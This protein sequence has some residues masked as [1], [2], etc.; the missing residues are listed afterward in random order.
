MTRAPSAALEPCPNI[1]LR[2]L[3]CGNAVLRSRLEHE[4]GASEVVSSSCNLCDEGN[5]EEL[6]Y[7]RSGQDRL[8]TYIEH[9]EDVGLEP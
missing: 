9:M 6:L 2:C 5:F 4:V 3:C 7:G 8:L 1:P